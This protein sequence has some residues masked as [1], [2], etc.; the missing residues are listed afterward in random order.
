VFLPALAAV[1][2]ALVLLP[3]PGLESDLPGL[4][5]FSDLSVGEQLVF[6]GDT[7]HPDLVLAAVLEDVGP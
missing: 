5:S 3:A 4:L 2:A 6:G 7:P 1:V